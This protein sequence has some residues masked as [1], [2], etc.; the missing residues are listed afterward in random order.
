MSI[1]IGIYYIGTNGNAHKF[2]KETESGEWFAD[3]YTITRKLTP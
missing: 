1:T 3:V 2:L